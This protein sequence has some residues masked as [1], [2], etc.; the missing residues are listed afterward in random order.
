MNGG[1]AD[2]DDGPEVPSPCTGV[3]VMDST[4]RLC[5]G[6]LRTL[7]E[8]AAWGALTNDEKRQVLEQLRARR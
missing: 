5:F 6:C 3:C 2:G 4:R 8:I 7:G 1:E